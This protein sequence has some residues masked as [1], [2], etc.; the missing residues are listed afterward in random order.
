M[1][2]VVIPMYK[3]TIFL[4]KISLKGLIWQT[5]KD[6]N[7]I[8]VEEEYHEGHE[9]FIN[10]YKE[11]LDIEYHHLKK[12][13][14]YA[15][16]SEKWCVGGAK[17]RNYG[18]KLGRKYIACLDQDDLWLPNHLETVAKELKA[19]PKLHGVY[20]KTCVIKLSDLSYFYVLGD[21]WNIKTLLKSNYICHSSVTYKNT[22]IKYK[23]KGYE[24]G[25]WLKWKSFV[26]KKLEMKLIDKI[27]VVS[28]FDRVGK[29]KRKI[30]RN[31]YDWAKLDKLIKKLKNSLYKLFPQIKH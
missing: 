26:H 30:Y 25:D 28:F 22:R 31:K 6:F 15:N 19:N 18:N 27:T 21:K 11:V 8:V 17:S 14:K 3:S 23:E 16:D 4:E 1:I 29:V 10:G 24:P 9:K 5:F 7:V 12:K 13:P 2:T 20:T